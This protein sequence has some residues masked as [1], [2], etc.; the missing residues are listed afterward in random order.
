MNIYELKIWMFW[1]GVLL[2]FYV[3]LGLYQ[4]IGWLPGG[5]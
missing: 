3:V 5:R 4:S 2:G 1:M